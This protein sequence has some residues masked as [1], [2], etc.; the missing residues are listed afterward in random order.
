MIPIDIKCNEC[1]A[2]MKKIGQSIEWIKK[3][4]YWCPECGVFLKQ[5]FGIRKDPDYIWYK[6]GYLFEGE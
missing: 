1:E 6:P 5:E 3:Q 4:F 2:E